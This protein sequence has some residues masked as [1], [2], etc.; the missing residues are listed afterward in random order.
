MA[1]LSD[2]S[3][4]HM[5]VK[6]EFIAKS[7]VAKRTQTTDLT[8]NGTLTCPIAEETIDFDNDWDLRFAEI[9]QNTP[10]GRIYCENILDLPYLFISV[11]N[12]E[13]SVD[14]AVFVALVKDGV[15]GDYFETITV[16]P[17]F[18]HNGVIVFSVITDFW[19]YDEDTFQT[20]NLQFAYRIV[21]KAEA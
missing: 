18:V 15:E 8:I 9:T 21:K 20:S 14:D 5:H 2:F 12:S 17:T 7:L 16:T 13:V 19:Y 3:G 6:R 10:M 1:S 11:A 4:N